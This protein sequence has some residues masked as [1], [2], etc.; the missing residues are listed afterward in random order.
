MR[1]NYLIEPLLA[2]GLFFILNTSAYAATVTVDCDSGESLNDAVIAATPG[3]TISVSGTCRE[4]I[5]ITT[6]D[7]TL[8]GDESGTRATLSGTT[9]FFPQSL[10]IIDGAVRVSLSGFNLDNGLFGVFAKNN[11]SVAVTNTDAIDNIIGIHVLT[12]SHAHLKDVN[13]TGTAGAEKMA[14]G[15]EVVDGS[16]VRIENSVNI[17]GSLAFG[18]DII[19]GSSLSLLEE[20]TFTSANNTLGGQISVNSAFFAAKNSTINTHNNATLGF[21]VN[22]GSTAMLFNAALNTHD[23]GLDGVDVV[24]AGNFEIDG[25]S[26]VTA[27][28]NGREGISIDDSTVNLFGFFSTAPG[29]PKIV[30]TNNGANGVLVEFGSKLDIGRNSSIIAADNGDA[31]VR[32]DD[33]S[34]AILQRSEMSGNQSKLHESDNHS[35][36]HEKNHNKHHHHRANNADVVVTFG[37][38]VSFRQNPDSAGNVTPNQ[39]SLAICDSSSLSRGDVKCKHRHRNQQ[40]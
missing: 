24:S 22:T 34:S 29:L 4:S 26:I 31:G 28:N 17:S 30:S 10:F 37:S 18:F 9:F 20:A 40:H 33:G 38:R 32:L 16:V 36:S 1:K 6:N 39:I 5:K 14:L 25:H 19:T 13:M 8:V 7:L 15:L 11:A 23:N 12:N 21:S 3:T 2:I 35:H 27:T